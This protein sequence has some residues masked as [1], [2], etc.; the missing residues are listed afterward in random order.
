MIALFLKYLAYCYIF[1]VIILSD[2]YLNAKKHPLH[3]STTDISY[4]LKSNKLEVICTIFTDDFEAALARRYHSKTDLS[5]PSMHSSMDILVKKYINTDVQLKTQGVPISLNY[6]GY[7]INNEA[8]NAYFESGKIPVPTRIDADISLLHNLFDDQ[9][10]IV[11]MTVNGS[12]KSS[13]LGF[14][15]RK[16]TQVF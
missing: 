7:E 12:R 4:N 16:I 1:P 6:V 5:K 14:P 2:S 8:V 3:V 11:H 15:E 10:N 13:Q 9:L